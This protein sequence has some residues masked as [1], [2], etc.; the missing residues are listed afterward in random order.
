MAETKKMTIAYWNKL[1]RESKKRALL[2][3]FGSPGIARTLVD[4]EP[5]PNHGFWK[6]AF[7]TIRQTADGSHYKTQVNG[8]Y[9]H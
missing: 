3:C 6:Y 2:K 5:R 1:S 7:E 8:W 4:D 9:L